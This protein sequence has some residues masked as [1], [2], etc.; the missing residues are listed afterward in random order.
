MYNPFSLEG[1]TIL[2]T[3]AS[4]GIGR[5]TAIECSKLGAN[6][7]I[8]SRRE[9][10]LVET[11]SFLTGEGHGY[12][13]GDLSSEDG[14]ASLVDNLPVLDGAAALVPVYASIIDCVSGKTTPLT[15][16]RKFEEKVPK[17]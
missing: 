2:I 9:D 8:T 7:I 11:I 1:K 15:F 10:A 6:I 13:V 4:S 16:F 3:G 12:I 14:C 5:T 17:N